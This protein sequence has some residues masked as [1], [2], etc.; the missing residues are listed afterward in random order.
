MGRR[1]E[2]VEIVVPSGSD[3]GV[4]LRRT[5][6]VRRKVPRDKLGTSETPGRTA[7]SAIAAGGSYIM[8]AKTDRSRF[9][10]RK[11]QSIVAAPPPFP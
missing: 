2:M 1:R 5:F 3:T 8:R 9:G 6:S 4:D 10:V 7:I 11:D